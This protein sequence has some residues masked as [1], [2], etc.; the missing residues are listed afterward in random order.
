MHSIIAISLTR[1]VDGRQRVGE[2]LTFKSCVKYVLASASD[3]RYS[4]ASATR[5]QISPPLQYGITTYRYDS[6]DMT[7]FAVKMCASA[8]D[9]SSRKSD[10]YV[11]AAIS[12]M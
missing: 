9:V 6:S 10:K 12:F 11:R 5:I 4:P 1:T 3:N 2:A 8:I 7:I